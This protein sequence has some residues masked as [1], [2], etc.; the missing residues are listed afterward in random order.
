M[1]GMVQSEVCAELGIGRGRINS[2]KASIRREILRSLRRLLIYA[3]KLHT[4]LKAVAFYE[5][6]A[7]FYVFSLGKLHLILDL[8]YV[9][10]GNVIGRLAN[11][12]PA[13]LLSCR[14]KIGNHGQ[15]LALIFCTLVEKVL[16]NTSK[17]VVFR[18]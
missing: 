2:R 4:P 15:V 9:C 8:L 6:A 10:F 16:Y 17:T 5:A 14:H 1:N 12:L 7:F 13:V 18:C 11:I 3:P